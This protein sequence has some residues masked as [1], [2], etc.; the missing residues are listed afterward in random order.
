MEDIADVLW[1]VYVVIH[2]QK[3]G[4]MGVTDTC[5][6]SLTPPPKKKT[7]KKPKIKKPSDRILLQTK[8]YGMP[9]IHISNIHYIFDNWF[10]RKWIDLSWALIY[11]MR[12]WIKVFLLLRNLNFY[13][14]QNIKC[15]YMYS[16]GNIS[17]YSEQIR[18][19]LIDLNN[20][21]K[22]NEN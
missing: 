22:S 11:L 16:F 4:K 17:N 15:A 20:V 10:M 13:T 21:K 8:V 7:L 6:R 14:R 3:S 5:S 2:R 18:N 19:Y 1:F 12:T 9:N